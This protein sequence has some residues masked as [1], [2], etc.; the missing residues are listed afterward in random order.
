MSEE[1]LNRYLIYLSNEVCKHIKYV[2]VFQFPDNWKIRFWRGTKAAIRFWPTL[3]LK[4]RPLQDR[5]NADAFMREGVYGS[6]RAGDGADD[7]L[8]NYKGRPL[9]SLPATIKLGS[10][11]DQLSEFNVLLKKIVL[12]IL[13]LT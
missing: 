5:A 7:T 9:P 13:I 2:Y 8:Y 11:Y 10:D 1:R 6:R 4:A 3:W 12:I